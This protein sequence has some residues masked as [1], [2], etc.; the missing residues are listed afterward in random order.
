MPS[1]ATV[2]RKSVGWKKVSKPLTSTFHF[3]K[4]YESKLK[5]IMFSRSGLGTKQQYYIKL[6]R[7]IEK[8][9]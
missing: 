3:L 7:Y 4:S 9:G 5:E 2:E 8:L 1:V 6:H